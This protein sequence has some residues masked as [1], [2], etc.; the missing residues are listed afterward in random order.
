M[1]NDFGLYEMKLLYKPLYLKL[2]DNQTILK[3]IEETFSVLYSN[4]TN[5]DKIFDKIK[6]H[7]LK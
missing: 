2:L 6:H 7:L 3:N 1:P 5:V 4:I